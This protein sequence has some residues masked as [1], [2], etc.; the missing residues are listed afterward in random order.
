MEDL[1][2]LPKFRDALSYLYIEH[3]RID[4]HEKSVACFQKEGGMIPIPAAA[5]AV[6]MLG[7]GTRITHAAIAALADNNC[8]VIWCG[9]EN[10]RLYACGM[11]GTRSAEPLL[12]QARLAS[13]EDSRL[14][15]VKRMYRMRFQE[16]VD[17]AATVQQLRGKEGIR[18]R[19]TYARMSRDTG[20]PWSGRSYDRMDWRSTDP[21]NRALSAANSCLYGVCHAAILSAGYSPAIG[22]IHTGKQLSFVYDIADLYKVEITIPLA[23]RTAAEAPPELER[24]VRLKLRD[25][26]RE[27]RLLQRI[28]PD[29]RSALG[30]EAASGADE[31]VPM[32]EDMALP[33]ALWT[34]EGETVAP[35][36]LAPEGEVVSWSS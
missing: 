24:F 9:E 2:Q 26:F 5:L 20:I 25:L 14:E 7:P 17:P 12:R 30:E 18:V 11:G 28:I 16:E 10:V 4:R 29:I 22:F 36:S 34:P 19:D 27:T 15:V 3:G 35:E 13:Q 8:L 6:L 1:H 21:V 31:P 32:D 23:F 33:T